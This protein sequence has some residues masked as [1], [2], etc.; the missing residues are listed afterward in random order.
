MRIEP[1]GPGSG[2]RFYRD[3]L[4]GAFLA[5]NGRTPIGRGDHATTLAG[6]G[7]SITTVE[8]LLAALAMM[9]VDNAAIRLSSDEVPIMDGS[10]APFVYLIRE[11]G[12]RS[13]GLPRRAIRLTR[14]IGVIDGDR[15][16]TIYPADDLRVTYTIDFP[17]PTIGRQTMT[18]VIDRRTFVNEI[19]PARTFCLLK[20][21]QALRDRGLAL[22]GSLANAVVVGDAGPLN[23]LRFHDEFIRHKILDL[24]GDLALM[25]RPVLGHVVAHKAGH[26]LHAALI[27]RLQRETGSWVLAEM[28]ET[29]PSRRPHPGMAEGQIAALSSAP[30]I[31]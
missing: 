3:D 26:A 12:L 23:G 4:N 14:P 16:V 24:I 28:P 5:L 8:H 2:I 20:D 13:Q 11:A 22:G 31:R 17:N 25:G 1:A 15:E 7:F 30:A 6:E 10:S 9:G 21:V 18:R 27:Q 19:A 29:T